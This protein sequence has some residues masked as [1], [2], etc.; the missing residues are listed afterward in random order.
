MI[1]VPN[2]VR[3][4][5]VSNQVT[6]IAPSVI[7][8]Y[9]AL[10]VTAYRRAMVFLSTNLA[11]FSRA[12]HRDGSRTERPHFLDRLLKWQPNGYQNST[13]FWRTWFFHAAHMGNGYAEIEWDGS[14]YRPAA[15]HNLPPDRVIPYRYA[16]RPADRPQQYYAL[17]DG[18]GR[19]LRSLKGAD[20]LH[21]SALSY[22]GMAGMDPIALHAGTFQR[23]LT[24]DK[25]QTRY[26]MKGT[27]I[28]GAI[29]IPQGVGEEQADQIVAT[30]RE[31]FHGAEAERDVLV[32]SD[33]AKL[34]NATLTP[35]QSQLVEQ[36]T[37]STK[38]IAQLTGVHPFYLYDDK[39][40]KYNANPEQAGIEVLRYTFRPWIEQAEDELTLKLLADREIEDGYRVRLNPD[41]LLRGD[42]KA[43]NESAA[44]T[45]NAGLR[46]R[47]EGRALLGLPPDPDPESDKLKTLGDT[48]PPPS[49]PGTGNPG[50][51]PENVP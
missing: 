45:V 15:F 28:R 23:A 18:A 6:V 34:N 10:S 7:S 11:S 46:T 14:G 44:S 37:Q 2:T 19:V 16:R 13:A 51:G 41:V 35:Q 4:Y 21:L 39:D 26:L 20:V 22:D 3:V 31:H 25:Y 9:S 1:P 17:T 36:G 43:V 48:S 30:L 50:E 49:P 12:V 38:Q 29:E 33:G 27:V 42:T 47:N 32:L 24:L 40:G 5:D 8:P